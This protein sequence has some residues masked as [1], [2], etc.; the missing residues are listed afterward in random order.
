MP[1]EIRNLAPIKQIEGKILLI[2]GQKVI[3][4]A[5]LACIYGVKTKVFNQ[6]VRRNLNK[7]PEDFMFQLSREEAGFLGHSRSHIVTL[8]RGQN[9]K[10]LPYAFTEHGAIMA[11]NILKSPRAVKMSVFVVR[12]F[13]R[14]REQL[15]SRAEMESRLA[16]I[17]NI[18]LSHDGQIRDLY[19]KIRPLLLPLPVPPGRRIGF[20]AREK[21]EK[22]SFKR[23]R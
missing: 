17:E 11:A 9:I 5:D 20:I 14:M 22:Y 18:L 1:K 23:K 2:R 15:L 8:K 7:F 6:A 16:Q 4:D 13:I 3:L 10:Y 19:E 21:S 12:A